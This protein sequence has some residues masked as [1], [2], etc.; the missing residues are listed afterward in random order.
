MSK[1]SVHNQSKCL[2]GDVQKYMIKD[3]LL[4]RVNAYLGRR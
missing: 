2:F 3:S 4:I 1:D